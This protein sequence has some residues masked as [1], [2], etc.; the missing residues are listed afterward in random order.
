[1]SFQ[2]LS[3]RLTALQES[4]AQLKELI[5]RLATIK[6]QPGSIPLDNEDGNVMTE[7][8]SEIQ[9]T[10][11]DQD[12]DLELLQE[13]VYDLDS[14]RQGSELEQQKSRLDQAV[15]R[16]IKEL[17]GYVVHLHRSLLQDLIKSDTLP[18]AKPL[19]AELS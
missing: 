13:D 19:S 11:K 17:K 10:L 2:T 5:E 12:E 15:K 7:L 8:A 9:Q 6:F 1:M 3:D 4:N 14:E 16:A 18:A